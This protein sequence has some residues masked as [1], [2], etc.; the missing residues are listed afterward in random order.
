MNENNLHID[1]NYL[2]QNKWSINQVWNFDDVKTWLALMM[3]EFFKV[4]IKYTNCFVIKN[5][6]NLYFNYFKK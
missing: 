2:K 3:I 5:K 1:C 4:K 6:D